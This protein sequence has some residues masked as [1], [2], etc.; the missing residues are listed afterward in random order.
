MTLA[1]ARTAPAAEK[2]S[3]KNSKP[4]ARSPEG[5]RP[6]SLLKGRFARR[7]AGRCGSFLV[8]ELDDVHPVGSTMGQ[9][10]F[11]KTVAG[12]LEA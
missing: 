10:Y 12:P 1:G 8:A 4:K 6:T 3:Y 2:A 7:A 9:W 11:E 5:G